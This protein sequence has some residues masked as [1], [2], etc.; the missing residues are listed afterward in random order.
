MNLKIVVRSVERNFI[1]EKAN[2]KID[3]WQEMSVAI[4]TAKRVFLERKYCFVSC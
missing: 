1:I 2:R 4:G 3:E